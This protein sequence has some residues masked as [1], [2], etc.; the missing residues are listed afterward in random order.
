MSKINIHN[1]LQAFFFFQIYVFEDFEF[2]G[3]TYKD[4]KQKNNNSILTPKNWFQ[5]NDTFFNQRM[6]RYKD[7]YTLVEKIKL[8]LSS[9]EKLTINKPEYQILKDRYETY[10]KEKRALPPSKTS[11]TF[12]NNFDKLEP[13]KVYEYF[14]KLVEKGYLSKEDLENYLILAFQDRTPPKEKTTFSN[15]H[16]GNI[17]AI[18]YKYYTDADSPHGKQK[19]YAELLGDYFKSFTTIKVMNNFA[20]SK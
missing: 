3:T 20:K 17:T 2:D 15:K 1:R 13:N 12:T 19:Q 18:F 16:I 4:E 14:Y 7:G 11:F 8:E 9:L 10:L 6:E 5:H